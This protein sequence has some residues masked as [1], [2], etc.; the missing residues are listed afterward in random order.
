MLDVY[1]GVEMNS[2]NVF[3]ES[4]NNKLKKVYATNTRLMGVVGVVAYYDKFVDIYHLDFEE[5]GIDSFFRIDI[6]NSNEVSR[7]INETVGGLGG[8]LKKINERQFKVLIKDSFDI[9][10]EFINF[11]DVLENSCNEI[12]EIDIMLDENEKKSLIN[13]ICI[14][15]RNDYEL[16]NYYLMREIAKDKISEVLTINKIDF[17]ITDEPY[18]LLKNSINKDKDNGYRSKSLIDYKNRYKL[19]TSIIKIKD[20]KIESAR[21]IE[22]LEISYIEAALI[23]NKKEYIV[24]Y[25]IDDINFENEFF[26]NNNKMM[27]N[28]YQR[29][30]LYTEYNSNNDH[31]TKKDYFLSDDIYGIYY[32]TDSNQLVVSSFEEKNIDEIVSRLTKYQNLKLNDE[33]VVDK[34]LIYSFITSD[35][36]DFYEFLHIE[37]RD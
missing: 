30:S 31:V 6:K 12:L 5:Y 37:S 11:F 7:R 20:S 24:I 22:T 27:K 33:F 19:I 32:F 23:L 29:G 26:S 3:K 10:D 36:N 4:Y 21:I 13:K 25:Y 14:K 2:I 15:F 18:T 28:D 35:Y 34:S 16:I 8:K 1:Q 17:P 9:N